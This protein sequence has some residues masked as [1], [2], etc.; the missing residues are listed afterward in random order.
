MLLLS[1]TP[2]EYSLSELDNQFQLFGESV[3]ANK[4]KITR[5]S[6]LPKFMVRRLNELQIN[7]IK[8]TRNMYRDEHRTGENAEVQN[9]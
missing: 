6:A 7:G 2:Y 5:E 4:D 3:L 8:H 9:E 1:A